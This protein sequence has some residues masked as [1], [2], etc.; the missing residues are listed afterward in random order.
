[1][2]RYQK[3]WNGSD[4]YNYSFGSAVSVDLEKAQY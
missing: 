1:M 3:L 2:S 4:I